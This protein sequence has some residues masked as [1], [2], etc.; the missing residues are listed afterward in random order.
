MAISP[1]LVYRL[2]T[3]ATKL[4]S[5]FCAEIEKLVKI[6]REMKKSKKSQNNP[7]KK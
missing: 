2:N 7:Q 5:N 3:V 6:H 4:L 1:Q